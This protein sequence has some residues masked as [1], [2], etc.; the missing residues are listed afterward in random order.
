[1]F[2]QMFTL[3]YLYSYQIDSNEAKRK[4]DFNLKKDFS[5]LN[6][7]DKS[8]ICKSILDIARDYP[9]FN[10]RGYSYNEARKEFNIK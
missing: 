10:Y 5:D 6:I 4:L 3:D 7:M 9:N 8:F 2:D 1:M